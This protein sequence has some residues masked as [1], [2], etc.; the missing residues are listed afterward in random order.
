MVKPVTMRYGPGR[1][2]CAV[3]GLLMRGSLGMG[4]RTDEAVV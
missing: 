4:M 2:G 3:A 1:T